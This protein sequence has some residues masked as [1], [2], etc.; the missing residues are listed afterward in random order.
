MYSSN[1]GI[2]FVRMAG[3]S[4]KRVDYLTEHF[5]FI[6]YGNLKTVHDLLLVA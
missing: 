5:S 4:Y 3:I 6:T 2:E 1:P